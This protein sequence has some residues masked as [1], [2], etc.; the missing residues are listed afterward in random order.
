MAIARSHDLAEG[1]TLRRDFGW[2]LGV[3]F[4]AY[5]KAANEA[6][7]TLPGGPRGHQVLEAA[8]RQPPVSQSVIAQEIGIDRTVM[9]YLLDD[10]EREGLLTRRPDPADR[11]SR[12]VVA[13]DKGVQRLEHLRALI[14]RAQD[15]VLQ[16]LDETDRTAL[17]CLMQRSALKLDSLDPTAPCNVIQDITDSNCP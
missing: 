1:D 15:Y 4:R 9:T 2:A 10:L 11:R 14:A 8:T 12:Q 5:L 7:G 13:T 17:R 6:T 16:D 3:V